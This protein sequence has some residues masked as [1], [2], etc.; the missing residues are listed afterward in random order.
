MMVQTD[1]VRTDRRKSRNSHIDKGNVVMKTE[2]Q[3]GP[4]K[5]NYEIKFCCIFKEIVL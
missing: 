2:N 3:F 4:L 5:T 1:A